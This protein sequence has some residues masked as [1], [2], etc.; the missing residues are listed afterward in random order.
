MSEEQDRLVRLAF[1]TAQWTEGILD[2]LPQPTVEGF[3]EGDPWLFLF[4]ASLSRQAG[5]L[6]VSGLAFAELGSAHLLAGLA[7]KSFEEFVWLKYLHTLPVDRRRKVTHAF[8]AFEL[9]TLAVGQMQTFGARYMR[10]I[11]FEKKFVDHLHE[12][13]KVA[14]DEL[15]AEAV[16]LGWPQGED[17]KFSPPSISTLVS[18]VGLQSEYQDIYGA[19]SRSVHF[20]V[21]DSLRRASISDVG[22]TIFDQSLSTFE[23]NCFTIDRQVSLISK[24]VLWVHSA[25]EEVELP[26]KERPI[27]EGQMYYNPGKATYLNVWDFAHLE[28]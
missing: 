14:R 3:M 4:R 27:A 20:S 25:V 23:Q 7:R 28:P 8:A 11:G 21:S 22:V 10:K 17:G 6:R 2:S 24:L 13:A 19:S 12:S 15:A 26:T 16:S 5:A 9:G 18:K 1:S